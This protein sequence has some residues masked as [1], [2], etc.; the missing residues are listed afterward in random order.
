MTTFDD[1]NAMLA[2]RKTGRKATDWKAAVQAME[3]GVPVTFKEG[4]ASAT[5]SHPMI[6]TMNKAAV[7]A[8]LKPGRSFKDDSVD[9]VFMFKREGGVLMGCRRAPAPVPADEAGPV[10][11]DAADETPLKYVGGFTDNVPYSV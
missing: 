1:F 6:T 8:G 11:G 7:E 3:P 5:N 10:N 2:G 4:L 9:V